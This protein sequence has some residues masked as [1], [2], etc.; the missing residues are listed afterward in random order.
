MAEDTRRPPL[1]APPDPVVSEAVLA[2]AA[3]ASGDSRAAAVEEV[4]AAAI[5]GSEVAAAA[6]SVVV[7]VAATATVAM[8]R[9]TDMARPL[10][11]LPAQVLVAA[12][13]TVVIGTA[14]GALAVGMIRAAAVAH[15]MTDPVDATVDATA[16]DSATGTGAVV[17]TS[18]LSA[19]VDQ[20]SIATTTVPEKTTTGSADTRAAMKILESF[21]ATSGLRYQQLTV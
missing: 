9:P 14:T 11:L 16:A 10:M 18:S 19:S 5:A 3:T 1:P 8:A 13:A 21:V 4:S 17:P 12:A 6:A 2:E 15:M 20:E 7:A